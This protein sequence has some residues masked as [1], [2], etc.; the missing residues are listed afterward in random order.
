MAKSIQITLE[1]EDYREAKAQADLRQWEVERWIEF[2]L[3]HAARCL[4]HSSEYKPSKIS[5]MTEEEFENWLDGLSKYNN[6]TP[7]DI[8]RM[9]REQMLSEIKGDDAHT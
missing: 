5:R 9:L 6:P 3:R 1:D 8:D 2:S 4:P 7:D